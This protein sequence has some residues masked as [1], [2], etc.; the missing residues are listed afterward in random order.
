MFV[1][2]DLAKA[3]FKGFMFIV[4]EVANAADQ[5]L[6]QRRVD[7]M[8]ELSELHLKLEKGEIDED[9]FDQREQEL[10]DQLEEMDGDGHG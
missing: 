8:S 2:D 5:E 4:R 1:F 6:A 3:P 10:L 7:L 9:Q